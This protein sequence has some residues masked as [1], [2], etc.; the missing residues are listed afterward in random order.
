MKGIPL[1]TGTGKLGRQKMAFGDQ[2]LVGALEWL[3][4]GRSFDGYRHWWELDGD[5]KID[6]F[7]TQIQEAGSIAHGHD[8]WFLGAYGSIAVAD[9]G[10]IEPYVLFRENQGQTIAMMPTLVTEHRGT[11]GARWDQT[12]DGLEVE[13]EAATQFG[14]TD[15]ATIPIGKTYAAHAH[16]TYTFDNTG[17]AP[18]IRVEINAA[19]GD[20][21]STSDVERFSNLFP[22]A[23]KHWGMMDFAFWENMLM[24]AVQVGIKPTPHSRLVASWYS[25]NSMEVTDAY[26]GPNNTLST[27]AASGSSSQMGNEI[28]LYY[29]VDITP[30]QTFKTHFEAGY[31]LFVPGS[32]VKDANGGFGDLA[33][34]VYAQGGVKF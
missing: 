34:F 22:T 8:A 9:T 14:E 5:H 19:S 16:A 6:I 17:V 7:A 33:H 20:D 32:G 28:D 1:V 21:P 23:H 3:S 30:D 26:R 12:F 27:G 13:V 31:G 2:R 25:H 10:V 24:P 4:Q 15:G 29:H 11:L 18:F